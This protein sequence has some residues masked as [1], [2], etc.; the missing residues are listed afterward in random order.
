MKTKRDNDGTSIVKNLMLK[1][2]FNLRKLRF[3]GSK[4]FWRTNYSNGGTSG[5]G[6]YGEFALF[7]ANFLNRF[8][9]EN[10][11]ST[12][13]EFGCGDGHQMSFFDFPNYI[14]LDISD[15]AVEMCKKQNK[16][17][18]FSFYQYDS[19]YTIDSLNL[20]KCDLAISLDVIYH[21]VESA[22]YTEH[23]QLLFTMANKFVIIYGRNSNEF[24]PA[25]YTFPREFTADI[26]ELFPNWTLIKH[27]E[28]PLKSWSDFYV[29]ENRSIEMNT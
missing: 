16:N 5:P 18:H 7:K 15:A 14:G 4:E 21:R 12:V 6:S 25:D 29:F 22:V 24:F 9:R 17:N 23:L 10:E 1:I 3:R 11:L 2:Y 27:V 19:I 13:I 28:N 26:A 20:H 8:V